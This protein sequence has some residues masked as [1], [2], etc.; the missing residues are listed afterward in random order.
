MRFGGKIALGCLAALGVTAVVLV[1][2]AVHIW[3]SDQG[4]S[5][6]SRDGQGFWY[7]LVVGL[8]ATVGLPEPDPHFADEA[9]VSATFLNLLEG[10]EPTLALDLT[11]AKFQ[12]TSS[13]KSLQTQNEHAVQ[14]L[15][16]RDPQTGARKWRQAQGSK[17]NSVT[18]S[19]YRNHAKGSSATEVTVRKIDNLYLVDSWTVELRHFRMKR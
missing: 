4:D 10:G 15:G 5:T 6:S 14:T 8:D 19:Y 16:K 3:K 7:W 9:L 1:S 13:A 18:F 11:S 17:N 12:E 2:V